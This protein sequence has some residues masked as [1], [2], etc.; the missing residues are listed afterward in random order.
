MSSV[1]NFVCDG[2]EATLS[3]PLEMAGID[4][5]CPLCGA[6]VISPKPEMFSDSWNETPEPEPAAPPDESGSPRPWL[7]PQLMVNE[8]T[9]PRPVRPRRI[10]LLVAAGVAV[11]AGGVAGAWK[12]WEPETPPPV[13]ATSKVEKAVTPPP[14][15]HD[16]TAADDPAPEITDMPA[17]AETIPL[18]PPVVTAVSRNVSSTVSPAASV[19]AGEVAPVPDSGVKSAAPAAS[20]PGE[21]T[22][23]E[24]AIRKVVPVKDHLAKPGNALIHFL[25]APTWRERL[26][27]SLA[28]DKVKPL[29]E[30]HYKTF[31]DGPIIPEDVQLTRIEATEEDPSKKYYAFIVFLPEF[32]NGIPVSVEDTK[33]GCLVEWCSFVEARDQMLAKYFSAFHKEPGT[34]RVLV[35]RGHYF[36]EDVPNQDRKE[37]LEAV[38]PDT[39]GPFHLWLDKDSAAWAKFF[40]RGERSRWDISSM[41]VITCQW[42]R[43]PKGVQYVRLREVVADSWHPDLLPA[44][45]ATAKK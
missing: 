27:Y 35:R 20:P 40:A 36:E 19:P 38:A 13:S 8:E 33:S 3:I 24:Q 28:P 15:S 29:M 7:Q 41:M 34:F 21:M 14:A 2:C 4:G 25:A 18:P 11:F 12:L 44:S 37:C 9:E 32:E 22:A 10:G 31:S 16:Y 6:H 30:E 42:E 43:T 39:T 17:P 26:K 1:V 5:P 23:A 45:P